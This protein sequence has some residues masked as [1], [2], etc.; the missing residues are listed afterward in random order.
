M[1]N[2]IISFFSEKKTSRFSEHVRFSEDFRRAYKK[3][4]I[5]TIKDYV[6]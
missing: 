4:W 5:N 3:T 2:Y 1:Y 6:P